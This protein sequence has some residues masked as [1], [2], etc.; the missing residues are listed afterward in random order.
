MEVAKFNNLCAHYQAS[1]VAYSKAKGQRDRAFYLVLVCLFIASLN[2]NDKDFIQNLTSTAIKHSFGP[3]IGCGVFWVNSIV[4]VVLL[5]SFTKYCQ[6]SLTILDDLYYLI[7][8]ERKAS[9]FYN[10][11]HLFQRESFLHKEQN[12]NLSVNNVNFSQSDNGSGQM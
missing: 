6:L 8:L 7:R 12:K 10:D 5:L 1:S 11:C 4:L 2:I 9:S 3:D